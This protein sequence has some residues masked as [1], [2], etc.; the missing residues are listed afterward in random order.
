MDRLTHFDYSSTHQGDQCTTFNELKGTSLTR[1][2]RLAIPTQLDA[3][4]NT[5]K[6]LPLWLMVILVLPCETTAQNEGNA[7]VVLELPASTRAMALGNAF[8]L[9]GTQ[10]DV[11]FY[12]PAV[13]PQA[14]GFSFGFQRFGSASTLL[15]TSSASGGFAVG[16][17]ALSF[18]TGSQNLVNNP[19]SL[20][21]LTVDGSTSVSELIGTIAYG[22]TVVG[23]RVGL[24]AKWIEQRVAGERGGIP[25]ADVGVSREVGP[26]TFGASVQN[27]GPDLSLGP[28]DLPAPLRVGFGV[29][30]DVEQ[31]GPLD[32]ALTAAIY[33]Q[34][35][36]GI[37]AGGG[38]EIAYWP[39]TGRTLTARLG[40][41]HE[42]HTGTMHLT[43]GGAVTLDSFSGDYAFQ[44]VSTNGSSHRAGITWR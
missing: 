31:L 24:A 32:V 29:S 38:I 33:R 36:G 2:P 18:G 35:D 16:I 17:Q 1:L 10:P 34:H 15:T 22:R 27:I 13:V 19:P 39:I 44:D 26:L 28:A 41:I 30:S 6:T 37:M 11:V 43:L 4:T 9:S 20:G 7:G 25:A 21:S 8:V 5:M 14:S 3:K 42:P 23:F 40:A 12:N